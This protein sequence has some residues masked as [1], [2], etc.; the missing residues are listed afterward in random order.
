MYMNF[1]ITHVI[2]ILMHSFSEVKGDGGMSIAVEGIAG[3]V[4]GGY[5]LCVVIGSTS[6]TIIYWLLPIVA[7]S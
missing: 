4:G 7:G 6:A 2:L 5:V 1:Q 3:A